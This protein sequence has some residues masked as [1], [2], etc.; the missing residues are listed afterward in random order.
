M[1]TAG[2]AWGRLVTCGRLAIGLLTH[3]YADCM[4][5]DWGSRSDA[6]DCACTRQRLEDKETWL[7]V[8]KSCPASPDDVPPRRRAP[9]RRSKPP[10]DVT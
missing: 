3:S 10:N 1:K 6:E 2:S 9:A 7:T 5:K 4:E 8:L